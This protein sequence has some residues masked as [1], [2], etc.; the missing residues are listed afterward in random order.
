[1]N[2]DYEKCDIFIFDLDKTIW[3][4]YNVYED[5]IWAKQLIPPYSLEEDKVIDDVFSYCILK[6]GIKE[7]LNFLHLRDKKIGFLSNGEHWGLPYNKQPS[8]N[9]LKIFGLYDFFNFKSFLIYKIFSKCDKLKDFG[10]CVMFDDNEKIIEEASKI[11]NVQVIDSKKI[12]NWCDL[13]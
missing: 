10:A 2:I 5:S 8:V 7:Y 4:T 1:L 12:N 11:E 3:D 9:I 13:I 6:P